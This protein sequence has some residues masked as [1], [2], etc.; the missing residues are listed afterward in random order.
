MLEQQAVAGRLAI[1]EVLV[2]QVAVKQQVIIEQQR[3]F[4]LSWHPLA[5]QQVWAKIL[6]YE[7]CTFETITTKKSPS[8]ML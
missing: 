2:K 5:W 4:P 6:S 8:L 7:E 1:I 3:L